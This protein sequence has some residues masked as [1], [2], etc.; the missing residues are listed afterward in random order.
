MEAVEVSPSVGAMGDP[1]SLLQTFG[2]MR[3]ENHTAVTWGNQ[4]CAPT[5]SRLS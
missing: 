5:V 2:P 3:V 1:P 4:H